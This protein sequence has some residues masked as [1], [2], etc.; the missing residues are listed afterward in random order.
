MYSESVAGCCSEMA[1]KMQTMN[2]PATPYL[3]VLERVNEIV[4]NNSLFS[5][6]KTTFL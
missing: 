1:T 2:D 5:I 6:Q 4:K 3:S